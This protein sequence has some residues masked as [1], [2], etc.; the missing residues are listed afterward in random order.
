[1]ELD[2]NSDANSDENS[3]ENCD[4]ISAENYRKSPQL[5]IYFRFEFLDG[6]GVDFQS[7]ILK[8]KRRQLSGA[9]SVLNST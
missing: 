3:D 4:E 1:V 5:L 2:A 8:I 6:K 9:N 7:K